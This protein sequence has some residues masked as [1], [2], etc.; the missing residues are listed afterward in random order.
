MV[1]HSNLFQNFPQLI[2]IHTFK[3]FGIDNKAEIDVFMELSSFFDDP[4]D[5]VLAVT[6][7]FSHIFH[8]FALVFLNEVYP[9]API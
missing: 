3:G 4:A 2:V 9:E 7:S 1:W 8:V 5:I 6:S